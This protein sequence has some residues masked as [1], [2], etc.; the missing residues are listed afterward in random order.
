MFLKYVAKMTFILAV[1][2]IVL[3]VYFIKFQAIDPVGSVVVPL[4]AD[5]GLGNQM[6]R[7]AAGYALAKKTNSKLYIL[8]ERGA[9]EKDKDNNDPLKGNLML[10]KFNIHKENIIYKNKI[11]KK[12][13]N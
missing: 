5:G 2:I 9:K 3:S 7:Y 10:G 13:F 6:F 1:I 8:V 4:K 11:N 12:I